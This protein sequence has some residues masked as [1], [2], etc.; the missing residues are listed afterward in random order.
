METSRFPLG[1]TQRRGLAM[2]LLLLTA[3]LSIGCGG[4]GASGVPVQGKVTHDGKPLDRGVVLFSPSNPELT[5]ARA[6]IQ[7][8]GTYQ[9]TAAPGEY[10]VVVNLFTETDGDLNPDD[11]GYQEPKSLLPAEYSSLMRTPLKFTVDEQ[12]TEINLEL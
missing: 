10:K 5:A 3:S 2:L 4:D 11:P 6:T 8:D 7:S 12:A 9:L 1:I